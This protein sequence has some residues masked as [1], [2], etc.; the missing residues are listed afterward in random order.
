M[1]SRF[2]HLRQRDTSVSMLRVKMSRRR[3][4]S[5]KENRERAMNTRRQLDKLPELEISSLDASIAVANMSIIQEK[6]QNNAKAAKTMAVEERLKQ[7]ERWKERKALQKEKDKRERERKGVF[8]TGLYHPMDTLTI[9]S[10][11]VVPAAPKRAKETKVNTAPSQNT[12][13]TRSMK[14]QQ[15]VQQPLKT[16]DPNT[17]A[18]KAQPAVDRSTRTRAAPLKP[19]PAP[20]MTRTK[21]CAVE[22]AVRALSTRSAN[23]PPVTAVPVVKDKPK[24]K[25][26]ASDVRTTRSRAIFNP[27]PLPSGRERKSKATVNDTTQPPVSKELELKESD[28]QEPEEKL[29]PPSPTPCSEEDDVVDQAQADSVPNAGPVEAASSLSSF[30][31]E[32]F[33]FQAP[34]GLSSFKFEPLTPRSADAFLTPSFNLPPA[35]VFN[36]EPKAELSEPSPPK[37]ACLS[38]PLTSPTVAPPTPGSPLES[39]HDVAYFRSEIANETD[40]LMTL[41]VCWESKVEDESIPEEMRDRMRTAVGQARLLMKERFNQFGGLVDDC[42]LGRGEKITTCTDLQGFWDM[43]YY[44]VEDV[45]KKF[46]ALKEAEGR[47]WVEEYKPLPRQRKGVKKPLAA[48]AKQTG[49]KAAAKSRLA[50]VKAAMK[51]RQQAA[52][53]ERATKDA[54]NSEVDPS[55]NSQDTQPQAEARLPDTVVFDGGFFQVESPAK[56]SGSV[57]RSSRL[58]AAV[59]P[60]ASPCS[61]YLTPRRV[62]RRSLALAKTPIQ[63]VASPAQPV[64]TPAHLRLNFDQTPAQAPEF[65]CGTPQSSR[66]RKDTADVSLCFSTVEEVLSDDTQPDG[67]PVKQTETACTPENPAFVP[68]L[69]TDIPVHSL[70]SISVVEEQDEPAEGVDADLPVSPRLSLFPCRTPRVSQ[71][72]EP[73]SS[74]SFTLSPCVSPSQPPNFSPP[75]VQGHMEVQESVRCTPDS[76]VV[77]EIPGLDFERYLQPSQRC[78]LSPRETVAMET[79][80]PMTED[81]E[82]ESPRG[83]YENLLTQQEPVLPA[84]PSVLNL[85]SPQVQTAESALLLF[86]PELKDRIRQSVCP[87]DLMVFTPPSNV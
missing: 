54:G 81:V 38:P 21:V 5:Q 64:V 51:A 82:M 76:S 19:A 44:Q 75:A 78:S 71:A 32:G 60:Q 67:S 86:T 9:V 56:P 37:S 69:S 3:S 7:L 77:E 62:T 10:L 61:N 73:S 23:R 33:V 35:P 26:A 25:A 47:G 15:Q 43:V 39:N 16:Q 31:P 20:L 12:R 58:S 59:L 72:L 55:L 57:R 36:V 46:D 34:A 48:P 29:H 74:L 80:S 65:Q 4:Q 50:A 24:D 8:K 40:R 11:P 27:V 68:E 79:L 45:N 14:Q 63:T 84:V 30:A 85:Q 41:C 70:P 83:Q 49:T 42:E 2:A 18:K 17:V 28:I 13:V 6:T 87:S 22:P 1:E 53:A 52:E 66:D